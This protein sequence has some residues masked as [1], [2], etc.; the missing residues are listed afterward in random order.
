MNW[1]FKLF[2][3]EVKDPWIYGTAGAGFGRAR[4]HRTTGVVQI[5]LHK[6]GDQG[7]AEDYYH[8]MH[9]DWWHTFTEDKK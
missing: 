3:R 7:R 6:A 1:L 9:Q 4:K 8:T 2:K 5:R